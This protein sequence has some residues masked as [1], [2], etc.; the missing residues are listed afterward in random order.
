[1]RSLLSLG[2]MSLSVRTSRQ[3]LASTVL[4]DTLVSLFLCGATGG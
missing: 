1:M 2:R 4:L 3:S